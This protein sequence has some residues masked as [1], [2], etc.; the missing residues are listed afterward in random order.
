[1]WWI[2]SDRKA[3]AAESMNEGSGQ[4]K[5]SL[6]LEP[7]LEMGMSRKI[8]KASCES[9]EGE[10]SSR[11]GISRR[12]LGCLSFLSFGEASFGLFKGLIRQEERQVLA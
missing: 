9:E 11:I 8:E 4:R 3:L 5:R 12:N 2:E 7:L 6:T 1:M 10:S